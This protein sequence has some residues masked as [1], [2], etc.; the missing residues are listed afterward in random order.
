[1]GAHFPSRRIVPA[2][3]PCGESPVRKIGGE[4][5]PIVAHLVG[6]FFALLA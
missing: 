4:D 1:M 6:I 5:Q 3:V 2:S